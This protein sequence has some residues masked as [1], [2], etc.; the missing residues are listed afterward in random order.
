MVSRASGTNKALQDDASFCQL[1]GMDA[2]ALIPLSDPHTHTHTDM[3]NGA[4]LSGG[5]CCVHGLFLRYPAGPSPA[6]KQPADGVHVTQIASLR[7]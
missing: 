1:V 2:T 7:H 4:G 6:C 5:R 3:Q